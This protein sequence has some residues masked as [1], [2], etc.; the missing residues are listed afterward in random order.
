M[1]PASLQAKAV[2]AIS[3]IVANEIWSVWING[4]PVML[5]GHKFEKD[6]FLDS[7][8]LQ[9]KFQRVDLPPFQLGTR[10]PPLCLSN[11]ILPSI[12]RTG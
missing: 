7:Q 10:H 3:F 5:I 2:I 11:C 9:W 1:P 4:D 6:G 8:H 12:E